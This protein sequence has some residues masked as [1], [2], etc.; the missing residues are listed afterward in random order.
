[1]LAAAESDLVDGLV[2]LS[3]PLHPP[4]KPE[5]SRTA[6]LPSLVTPSLFV[7]GSRDSMGSVEEIEEAVKLIPARTELV[8]VQRAGHELG[9]KKTMGDVVVVVVEAFQKFFAE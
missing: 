2:L 3:Y 4:K 6:H 1:M 9:S 7:H 5:Q 8:I